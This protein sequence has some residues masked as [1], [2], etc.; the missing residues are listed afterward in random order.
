M[1]PMAMTMAPGVV[2]SR[3]GEAFSIEK[4]AGPLD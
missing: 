3:F 2:E 1:L 4:I